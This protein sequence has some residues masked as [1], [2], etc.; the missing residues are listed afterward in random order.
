VHVRVKICWFSKASTLLN[1]KVKFERRRKKYH[2]KSIS[3][4][5][6]MVRE[7]EIKRRDTPTSSQQQ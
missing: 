6:V 3:I 1:N 2:K 7:L 5:L 4:L